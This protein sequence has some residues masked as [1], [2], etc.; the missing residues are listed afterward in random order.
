MNRTLLNMVCS[1]LFFK[2]VKLMFWADAVLCE[3]YSRD[4]D[5][6]HALE[7]NIPYEMWYETN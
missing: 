1:M 4:K 6:Y 3:V 7:N 2:N 5:P